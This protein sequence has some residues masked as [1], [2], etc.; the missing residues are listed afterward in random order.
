MKGKKEGKCR[1]VQESAVPLDGFP[2]PSRGDPI[3]DIYLEP[4]I[5]FIISVQ[6]TIGSPPS[7]KMLHQKTT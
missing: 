6:E 5:Y 1:K 7:P 3:H 2:P 4:L